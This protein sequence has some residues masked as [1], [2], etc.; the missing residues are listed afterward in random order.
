MEESPQTVLNHPLCSS[1][2][3]NLIRIF[4]RYGCDGRYVPRM[5]GI[6][7]LCLLR[8]PVILYESVRYNRRIARQTLRP[9]PVFIIGHWRS[10]TTHLQNILCSDPQF[11][12]V[13]LGQAAMPLDFL[14]LGGL[15]AGPLGKAL[16]KK[17]LMD[18]MAVAADCPWEEELALVS[19][20]PLSFYHVSFFPR[21][22]ER[23]FRE[24]ILFD[25]GDRGLIDKWKR[26][27]SWFMRKVQMAD[28]D[29]VFL[30]KNPANSVRI[31][32]ILELFPEARFIHIHRD[33][34]K[35]FAS[36]VHLYLKAQQAWAFHRVE[37][38]RIVE[39][40]LKSYPVLMNG[41]LGQKEWIPPGRL[42]D[43]RFSD[44]QADPMEALKSIYQRLDL[45][46]FDAAE[47]CFRKYL[48]SVRDYRKN[49]L[50]LTPEEEARVR[51]EWKPF[52][53]R[54]GYET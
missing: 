25:G 45:D 11:A 40:V 36:T 2:L 43:V 23:I 18:N 44:L 14:T 54:L 49:R 4:I 16:P 51:A 21:A 41:F 52:F 42:V 8:Q 37:R 20:S 32:Q 33:P 27:Y 53:G 29:K 26:D 39:H 13:T 31:P 30:L 10:G 22:V 48:E 12:H 19:T 28:P 46:G 7:L 35:V 24:S 6:I 15:L 3:P 38:E 5:L 34:C 17:R 9:D 47:P 50:E 1:S